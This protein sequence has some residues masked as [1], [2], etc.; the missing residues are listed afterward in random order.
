MLKKLLSFGRAARSEPVATAPSAMLP[1]VVCYAVGD[2]HGRLDLLQA[3]IERVEADAATLPATRRVAMILGDC[4]DR[5]PDSKGVI[6]R[7]IEWRDAGPFEVQVLKGNHEAT[8]LDFLQDAGAGQG[9]SSFGGDA[10]L[11]SYGVAAPRMRNDMQG[12]EAA[13][14]AFGHAL[15][16]SHLRFLETLPTMQVLGDY[17]FVHAGLRPGVP[18]EEQSDRD[19][20][21]IRGE[22][23]QS[24]HTWEKVVV[25]G[26]TP[27]GEPQDVGE[28]RIGVDTGAYATGILTAVR[29]W[30]VQRQF[31][32]ARPRS[33]SGTGHAPC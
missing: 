26:H 23:L 2:I 18:L 14:D 6:Q 27:A 30:N 15:P 24:P 19:L 17:V 1:G 8:A 13:R 10:T 21:W 11:A 28:Y 29:L 12:W 25:H 22:F 33:V 32:Q 5:G 31:I 16:P 4:I 20:L 9:W 7:L 3:M